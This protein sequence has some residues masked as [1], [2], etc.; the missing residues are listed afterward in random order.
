[1]V[2]LLKAENERRVPILGF[3]ISTL[4]KEPAKINVSISFELILVV[5]QTGEM[6]LITICL[7]GDPVTQTVLSIFSSLYG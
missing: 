6:Q 2:D 7:I 3:P 4:V 1:M 5:A